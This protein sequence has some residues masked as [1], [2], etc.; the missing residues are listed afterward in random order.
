MESGLPKQDAMPKDECGEFEKAVK[1]ESERWAEEFEDG[2]Y[3]T[4]NDVME[5]I[6][7]LKSVSNNDMQSVGK[8]LAELI[9]KQIKR[10]AEVEAQ[11]SKVVVPVYNCGDYVCECGWTVDDD[12]PRI[13]FNYCAGCGAKL[14]WSEVE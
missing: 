3:Y 12:D 14:D 5:T 1:Y 2:D 4:L 8:V 9:E 7:N 11:L 13:K 6:N 10:I